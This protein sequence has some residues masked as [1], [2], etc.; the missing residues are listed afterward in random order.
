MRG[1]YP[2]M[3]VVICKSANSLK[4]SL[5]GLVAADTRPGV[6]AS[7]VMIPEYRA[8]SAEKLVGKKISL[9]HF[10]WGG[11]VVGVWVRER[12]RNGRKK[13]KIRSA[14]PSMA[15]NSKAHILVKTY[16]E[17]TGTR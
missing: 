9:F 3:V 15:G 6:P 11:C 7:E 10:F 1:L 17:P 8:R 13:G 5:E 16:W 4:N 2:L 12:D 14:T